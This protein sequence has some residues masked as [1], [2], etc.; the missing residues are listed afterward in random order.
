MKPVVVAISVWFSLFSLCDAASPVQQE[1]DDQYSYPLDDALI[2][3]LESMNH[4]MYTHN[5]TSYH[6]DDDHFREAYLSFDDEDFENWK[7]V[8]DWTKQSETQESRSLQSVNKFDSLLDASCNQGLDSDPCTTPFSSLIQANSPTVVPCGT[9]AVVDV[10]CEE[11]L[12]LAGL[13]I[14]GKLVFPNN[15]KIT[16]KTPFVYVQGQLDISADAVISPENL[17][18][19]FILTG[20]VNQIFTPH[21]YNS[22][23]C[24]GG[25]CAVGKKPF[26]VAGGRININAYPDQCPTW[27][28]LLDSKGGAAVIPTD[29]AKPVPARENCERVVLSEDFEHGTNHWKGNLGARFETTSENEGNHYFKVSQRK[30]DWQGKLFLRCHYLKYHGYKKVILIPIF[31]F[32]NLGFAS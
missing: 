24:N 18:V 3:R 10:N 29:W 7:Y 12:T 14:E 11:S 28:K 19:S 16:I 22:N 32:L 13:N 25:S 31:F 23:A 26:L 17:A 8:Q 9:C 20:A 1:H 5:I 6:G 27:V 30:W 2:K 15:R 4:D 21:V